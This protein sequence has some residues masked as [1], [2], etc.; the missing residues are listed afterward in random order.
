M[1]QVTPK[2]NE[3]ITE[4][5][6][7]GNFSTP[8]TTEIYGKS[9]NGNTIFIEETMTSGFKTMPMTTTIASNFSIST[10]DER[11]LLETTSA[12]EMTTIEDKMAILTTTMKSVSV[13]TESSI[14]TSE[15]STSF[16]SSITTEE[17][18]PKSTFTT[19]ESIT[20]TPPTDGYLFACN[21]QQCANTS[22]CLFNF[23]K[24]IFSNSLSR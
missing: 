24:V 10:T 12:E 16:K 11:N 14:L 2:Q 21:L 22:L 23:T 9:F 15:L 20:I 19:F 6:G 7:F 18:F 8:T 13:T 4:K 17:S 3:T 1:G 5:D